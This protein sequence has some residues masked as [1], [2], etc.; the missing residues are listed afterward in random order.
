MTEEPS[1]SAAPVAEP[2]SPAL[3]DLMSRKAD[4]PTAPP[5][6]ESRGASPGASD[7]QAAVERNRS[8]FDACVGEAAEDAR[9]AG[10][11]VLLSVTVNP[12]GI[13]TSPRLDDAELDGSAAGVCLKSA[14]RKL[15]LP[16]FAGDPV[17]VRVPLTLG[18]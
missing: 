2:A 6:P 4:A 12:S 16:A 17:R 8:A 1:P 14:A 11:Q 3:L 18:P 7:V 10:R 15:V 5:K 13:V 9:L